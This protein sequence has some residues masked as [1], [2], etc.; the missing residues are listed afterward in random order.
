VTPPGER[1]QQGGH[2]AVAVA[3]HVEAEEGRLLLEQHL[4]APQINRLPCRPCSRIVGVFISDWRRFDPSH[5]LVRSFIHGAKL[6]TI[7]ILAVLV[8]RGRRLP[9]H[10]TGGNHAARRGSSR[11]LVVVTAAIDIR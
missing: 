5:N 9:Q 3:L 6:T 2:V 1:W 4:C 10:L 8:R 7:H 11:M